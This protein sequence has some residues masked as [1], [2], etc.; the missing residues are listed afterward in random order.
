MKNNIDGSEFSTTINLMNGFN[1]Y[2]DENRIILDE[3]I[4]EQIENSIKVQNE[5][6]RQFAIQELQNVS[7]KDEKKDDMNALKNLIEYEIPKVEKKLEIEF[8]KIL[9]AIAK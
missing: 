6:F 9:G 3:Q 4:C 5:V 2:F 1:D 8:K 7:T